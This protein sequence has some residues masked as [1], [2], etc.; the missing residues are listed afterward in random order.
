MANDMH[1]GID[2]RRESKL[3]PTRSRRSQ[4]DWPEFLH[5]IAKKLYRALPARFRVFANPVASWYDKLRPLRPEVWRVS[6]EEKNTHLPLEVCLYVV[7]KQYKS[8]LIDLIFGSSFREQFLGRAWLWSALKEV[9]RGSTGSSAVFAE[10]HQFHL[11]Y[12][13][14]KRGVIIPAWIT[15]EAPLEPDPTTMRRKSVRSDARKIETN[16]LECEVTHDPKCFEDFYFNMYIPHL[17]KT[18]GHAAFVLSLEKLSYRFENGDLLLIKK[19]DEPIGGLLLT[20]EQGSPHIRH[21][22]VRDGNRQFVQEGAIAAAYEH[23]FRHLREKGYTKVRLGRSRAF[24]RDGVLQFKK[25]RSQ[26]I[27]G[28]S[29]HKFVLQVL[30]D[31]DATWALLEHNPFMFEEGDNVSGAVFVSGRTPLTAKLLGQI[32][33]R[34][35]HVGL[36]RLVVFVSSDSNEAQVNG[37]LSSS[38]HRFRCEELSHDAWKMFAKSGSKTVSIAIYPN[39][40]ARI[41]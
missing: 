33:D 40:S 20:Y 12:L 35:F 1:Q 26:A 17:K 18:Y 3:E 13:K 21:V 37:L 41:Q 9:P 38:D 25:K 10:V 31:T 32:Y 11:K 24:L 4:L 14:L 22:G 34:Y 39:V 6:G 16:R 2:I 27:V 23:A 36:S 5:R 28:I 15:G 30:S 7:T 29:T 19:Q 8:Y